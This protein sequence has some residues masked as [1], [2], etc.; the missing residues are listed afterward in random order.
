[1]SIISGFE[2]LKE[3]IRDECIV[4]DSG[5]SHGIWLCS[6]CAHTIGTE[7]VQDVIKN[8][9]S[10]LGKWQYHKWI[11]LKLLQCIK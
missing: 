9:P 7:K 4:C 2:D 10:Y 5:I 1:M 3:I 8:I 11:R 6:A